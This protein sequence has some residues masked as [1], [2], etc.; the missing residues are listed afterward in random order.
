[1]QC[2]LWRFSAAR[3]LRY[4]GFMFRDIA[5]HEDLTEA[6]IRCGI[7]VH[8]MWGP[9]LLESVY[10]A[11]F[12]IELQADGHKVDGNRRV[13]LVYKAY[14]LKSDFCPDVVV[15]DVVVI[16]LKAVDKLAPVHKAQVLCVS[17]SE[18]RPPVKVADYAQ[19]FS[20]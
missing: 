8:E 11:C 14:D 6:I 16:E 2:I 15:D 19:G 13:H 10:K 17:C 18:G 3:S 1:M 5:G 7:R 9:G 4:A 12:I 20:R